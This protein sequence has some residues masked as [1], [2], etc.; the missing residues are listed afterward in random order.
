ME[1]LSQTYSQ[2]VSLDQIQGFFQSRRIADKIEIEQHS[3]WWYVFSSDY[4]SEHQLHDILDDLCDL[5]LE[6]AE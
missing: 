1:T 2:P 6:A 3:D 5:V 4:F